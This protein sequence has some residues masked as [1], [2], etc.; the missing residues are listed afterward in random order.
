MQGKLIYLSRC[1]KLSDRGWSINDRVLALTET[2]IAYFSKVPKQLSNLDKLGKPKQ[3][4]KLD[5]ITRIETSANSSDKLLMKLNSSL[6]NAFKI[7]FKSSSKEACWYVSIV[8][9]EG[10]PSADLWILQ[11]TLLCQ[12]AISDLQIKPQPE[13]SPIV[14]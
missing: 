9:E 8:E 14:T 11:L 1:Q 7:V 5:S 4:V 2:E 12:N 13:E 3:I 10:K 6:K